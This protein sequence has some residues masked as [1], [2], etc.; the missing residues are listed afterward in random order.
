MQWNVSLSGTWVRALYVVFASLVFVTLSILPASADAASIAN[1][2]FEAGSGNVATDWNTHSFGSSTAIFTIA[3]TSLH[4]GSGSRAAQVAITSY[5]NGDAKWVHNPVAVTE[6]EYYTFSV[7]YKS[8]VPT[9]LYARYNNSDVNGATTGFHWLANLPAAAT[10]TQFTLEGGVLIPDDVT[11]LQLINILES[12]GTLVVDDYALTLETAPTFSEGRVTFTFDDG[13]QSIYDNARPILNAKNIDTTQYIYSDAMNQVHGPIFMT[14][15]ELLQMQSEGHDIDAH[16]RTHADLTTLTDPQLNNEI[17]GSRSDLS[18]AGFTPVDSYAY[19]YGAYNADIKARMVA[20]GFLGARTVDDGYNFTNADKYALKIK[21]VTNTTTL[22]DV[23]NWI[24]TAHTQKSWLILMFHEV[25]TAT[26]SCVGTDPTEC[27]TTTLLQGI[28][29]YVTAP[30][31]DICILT[32]SEAL[33]DAACGAPVNQAPVVASPIADQ[34]A[35]EDMLFSYTFPTNTFT[36]SNGDALTYSAP[37]LPAWMSFDAGTRTFTGTPG[38]AD[39]GSHTVVVRASDSSSASTTDTFLVTVGNI[40]SAPTISPSTFSI[41]ENSAAGTFVGTTTASDA[42]VGDTLSYEIVSGN[43]G[44]AFALASNTGVITV[45]TASALDFET[46]PAF[47]LVIK[48]TDS[49]ALS[50]TAT[51]TI[52]LTDVSETPVPTPTPPPAQNGGGGGGGGGVVLGLIGTITTNFPSV[53]VPSI[54]SNGVVLGT[55]TVKFFF[56][57]PLLR[58]SRGDTVTELHK[59]LIALGFLKISAPTGYF[60][61][62][63]F[64]A[65]KEY[66]KTHGIDQVGVVGPITRA[67]LNK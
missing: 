7:W 37:T 29:D 23:Q 47:E 53:T 16:S 38:N 30:A 31:T 42:D 52:T 67:S 33:N 46:S 41:A 49:S 55:S 21:H 59:I 58:G 34:T 15:A 40:N 4:A 60:G 28:V 50:A 8:T 35:T 6:N 45:A 62:L 64:A 36:D 27:S 12:A 19:P 43:T 2:S 61:P 1:P 54:G 51:T 32:M 65:V 66:Q 57:K 10:W 11:Q 39:V 48:V 24:E 63:T 22:V 9:V 5:T 20:A 25:R 3:T 14:A 13:L 56:T 18:I 44:G 26:S 17:V